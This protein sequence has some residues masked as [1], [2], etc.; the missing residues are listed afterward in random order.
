MEAE[1]TYYEKIPTATTG[2]DVYFFEHRYGGA[3]YVGVPVSHPL[4][5]INLTEI[6]DLTEAHSKL[7][8]KIEVHGGITYSSMGTEERK[9]DTS[10]WYIG[11]DAM[12]HAN[13]LEMYAKRSYGIPVTKDFLRNETQKLAN[14][15]IG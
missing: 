10:L 2:Y 4:Y 5:K 15:L 9:E 3:G 11:W 7:V 14:Q 8:M 1:D 12:H 13:M 6:Q